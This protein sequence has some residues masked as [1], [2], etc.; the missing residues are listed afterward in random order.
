MT[1]VT[2]V[3]LACILTVGM[4]RFAPAD[5]P[6]DAV[7]GRGCN[8]GGAN[9]GA[10]RDKA[11]LCLFYEYAIYFPPPPS[12]EIY[13]YYGQL[14]YPNGGGTVSYAD[15]IRRRTGTRQCSTNNGTITC[16]TDPP[17]TSNC[18]WDLMIRT[19]LGDNDPSGPPGKPEPH[20]NPGLGEQGAK[21]VKA[22]EDVVILLPYP[23]LPVVVESTQIV[24]LPGKGKNFFLKLQCLDLTV[25]YPEK[26]HAKIGVGRQC[27][28]P[29]NDPPPVDGF[30]PIRPP[31][32]ANETR[33]L[34][35]K[36]DGLEYMVLLEDPFPL[37]PTPAAKP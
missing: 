22:N 10:D 35:V 24:K 1:S 37:E 36:K 21:K 26:G 12:D 34:I 27:K 29:E 14:C 8:C 25:A 20:P 15:N 9:S 5:P 31:G 18:Y 28:K 3:L 32:Q 2:N 17:G 4:A 23:D 16:P 13:F 7:D 19:S 30:R 6:T 11:C 33:C